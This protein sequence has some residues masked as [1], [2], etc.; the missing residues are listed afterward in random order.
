MKERWFITRKGADFQ[1]ISHKFR[2]NMIIARLIRNRDVIGDEAIQTYLNGGLEDLHDGR[3]LKGMDLAIDILTE[4]IQLNKKIRVIG[5]YDIDG[6]NATY[7]L[8]EGLE[9]VGADVDSDIPHRMTDGYGLSI[10]LVKRAVHA[11]V[12]TIVTCD[13]GISAVQ[14]IAYAKQCGLTVIITDHHEVPYDD[15]ENE[16]GST[17]IYKYPMADAIIDPK[18]E[19]CMY[20]FPHICGAMVAYKLVEN[21]Y[22]SMGNDSEDLDYLIE[23]VAIATIGDVMDLVGENRIIVKQGL[24]MLKRT[25]N[26]GMQA[27]IK[28]TEIDVDHLN[29]YHIGFVIGPCLNASGR[30]DTAKKAL[31]LLRTKN[32]NQAYIKATELKALNDERKELTLQGVEQAIQIIEKSKTIDKVLVIYLPTCHESL[33]GI[34][35]GRIRERYHRPTFVLTQGEESVKG[36]GRSIEEYD[37]FEE[38]TKCKQLF[39]KY[40]GHKLAAGLS[41][42]EELVETLRNTLNKNCE[43]NEEDLI[44]KV[45]IDMQVPLPYISE[46]LIA[47]LELLE[48]YGKANQKPIFVEKDIEISNIQ[49]LGKNRN[50]I[51]MNLS[52]DGCT[53]VGIY[54][55]EPDQFQAC[56]ENKYGQNAFQK[57]LERK[58]TGLKLDITFYPEINTFRENKTIQLIIKNMR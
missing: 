54:F 22:Q 10:D 36:S 23:N 4:K 2:I 1:A 27:L 37:M 11:G 56:I 19:K 21:L 16:F 12:D 34:I 5:D 6:I 45:S 7:I 57:V 49:V 25:N 46:E 20:P 47:Q 35:A 58:I 39:I 15:V 13:N 31:E 32:E 50:V 55:G 42:S 44:P 29:A 43:L 18:Q 40:G 8:L 26:L 41:I 48:P 14:E 3:L 9:R 28:S 24:E 17:R 38:M 30:L 52:K 53:L 33:A 51:K